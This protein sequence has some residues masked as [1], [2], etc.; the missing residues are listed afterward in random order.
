MEYRELKN[1]YKASMLGF[2]CM[3]FPTQADGKIDRKEAKRMLLKAYE[4]GVTYFDTAYPYHGGESEEVVGEVMSELPRDSYYLA[5]KLPCWLVKSK[6]DATRLFEEQLKKLKTDYV[7]FYLLHALDKK[8]FDE[9]AA[10]GVVEL[11]QEYKDKGMIKNY[12]FSFHDN[13]EAFEH[14]IRYKD[15]WDFCQIQFNYV[16]KNTQA[17]LKGYELAK[18]LNVPLVIMEPIKGG[19]LANIPEEIIGSMDKFRT[20]MSPAAWALSWVGTFDNCK[21]ILSGM[22]TMEQVEDNLNTFNNFKALS[23][24]EMAAMD[25]VCDE[26]NK[27]AKN[28]CTGCRYCMPCPAGVNIPGNFRMWNEYH[29]YLNKGHLLWAFGDMDEKE[30]PYSCVKCGKCE[31]HCPQHLNIRADLE[32]FGKEVKELKGEA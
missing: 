30:R 14:I 17:T 15:D 32:A 10:L 24:E 19:S 2:G 28:G 26:I 18:E 11:M 25:V 3:R 4:S 23:D 22:S 9:M 1:G 7:D 12:G 5:T 8:R 31:T 27:R 20:G 29:K 16:D 13:Y 21:V 6:E